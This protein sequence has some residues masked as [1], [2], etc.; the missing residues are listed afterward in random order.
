M[1]FKSNN[2]VNNTS[3]KSRRNWRKNAPKTNLNGASPFP[4]TSLFAPKSMDVTLAYNDNTQSRFATAST[5]AFFRMRANSVFDPDPLLATGGISG[6]LEWGS[7]YR[8]YLVTDVHVEWIL[9]NL[10]AHPVNVVFC[11]STVDLAAAVASANA[12][13]DLGELNFSVVRNLSAAGGQDRATISKTINLAKLHGRFQQYLTDD[14]YSGFAG[15]GPTN[16]AQML[17]LNFG[18]WSNLPLTSGID[19][20][21]RIKYRVTWFER[22]SPLDRTLVLLDAS[23]PGECYSGKCGRRGCLTC[24]HKK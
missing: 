18:A 3:S 2:I 12:V 17:F 22:Q 13:S 19:C 9:S 24:D 20:T 10:N 6:F 21:L 23:S 14:D 4:G 1:Y 15:T 16:P 8:K 5:F 7:L 11:A